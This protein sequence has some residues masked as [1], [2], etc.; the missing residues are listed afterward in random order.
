M[1]T[2]SD[3]LVRL[4]EAKAD[5]V[6]KFTDAR[7]DAYTRGLKDGALAILDALLNEDMRPM[8]EGDQDEIVASLT[9]YRRRVRDDVT[10][11]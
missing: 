6:K 10:A 5:L 4:D 2:N 7:L 9:E 11:S 8:F 3:L 1:S